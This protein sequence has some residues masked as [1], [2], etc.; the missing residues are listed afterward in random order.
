[1]AG[2]EAGDI[3]KMAI[4]VEWRRRNITPVRNGREH[5]FLSFV[6]ATVT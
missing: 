4:G 1:M 2:D 6:E 3:T 5:G